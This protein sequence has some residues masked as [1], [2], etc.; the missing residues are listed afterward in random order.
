MTEI[1]ICISVAD[2]KI[3]L[4]DGGYTHD[5]LDNIFE[6]DEPD[7]IKNIT[8]STDY[9]GIKYENGHLSVEVDSFE[10]ISE[11]VLKLFYGIGFLNSMKIFYV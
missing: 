10:K 8:A 5:Y 4:T 1:I 11:S 2:D 6:L 9:F 7:V 3:V